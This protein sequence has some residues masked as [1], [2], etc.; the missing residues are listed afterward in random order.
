MNLFR[1][2]NSILGF[3][4]VVSS[5]FFKESLSFRI[6]EIFIKNDMILAI[7]YQIIKMR[8]ISGG[9][10][11]IGLALSRQLLK[12]GDEYMSAHYIFLLFEIF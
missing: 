1:F 2:D 12:L 5:C 9:I 10:G 6:T 8:E 3:V 7:Y 4:C 11:K